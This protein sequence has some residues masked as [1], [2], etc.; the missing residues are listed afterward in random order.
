MV[1]MQANP[2]VLQ[3]RDFGVESFP[4]KRESRFLC[5]GDAMK[6]TG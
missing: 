5:H 2:R 1:E 4:C 3:D 6:F